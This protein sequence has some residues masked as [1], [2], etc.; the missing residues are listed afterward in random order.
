ML[1][2]RN[3]LDSAAKDRPLGLFPRCH[4]DSALAVAYFLGVLTVC[5]VRC[6]QV[7]EQLAV[8]PRPPAWEGNGQVQAPASCSC[9]GTERRPAP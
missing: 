8:A 5:C 9:D 2:Y 7:V 3:K 6:G 1:T 4:P